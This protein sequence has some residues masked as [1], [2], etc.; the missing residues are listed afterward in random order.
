MARSVIIKDQKCI[1]NSVDSDQTLRS[2]AS[3]LGSTVFIE[4]YLLQYFK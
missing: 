4:A 2:V 3:D 1:V